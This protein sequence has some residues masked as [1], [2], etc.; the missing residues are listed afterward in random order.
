MTIRQ[1][2][3]A[4]LAALPWLR[5]A[6]MLDSWK[7]D[8]EWK[9]LD[10][11]VQAMCRADARYRTAQI[12]IDND[13]HESESEVL[14]TIRHEMA[15]ILHVEFMLYNL[16]VAHLIRQH[17]RN[18]LS[19]VYEAAQEKTVAAIEA[20]LET[21]LGLTPEKMIAVAKRRSGRKHRRTRTESTR[22]RVT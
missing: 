3:K 2:R 11:G 4:T 8:I 13:Q 19:E 10:S 20:M 1:A 16:A 15:H 14:G 21:G 22:P 6:M 18:A 9:A 17:E 12:D 5:Y 7:I